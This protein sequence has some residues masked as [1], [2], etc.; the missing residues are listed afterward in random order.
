[1]IRPISKLLVRKNKSQFRLIDNPDS[2]DWNDILMNKAK[3]RIYDD[4]LVFRET[5][6]VFRLKGDILSMITVYDFNNTDS[7]DAKQTINFLDEMKFDIYAKSESFRDMNFIKNFYN[8]RALLVPGL[9]EIIFLLEKPND[10]CKR[11]RLIIHEKQAGNDTNKFD[12]EIVVIFGNLLEYISTTPKQR[13]QILI[14]FKLFNTEKKSE[15]TY[16]LYLS[17]NSH[18]FVC[19]PKYKYSYNRMYT[20]V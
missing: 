10:F 8:K 1:M 6:V 9:H 4:K 15:T 16:Y 7:P 20:Q 14:K 12:N 5:G 18:M 13:T 19:I 17:I 2:D 11:L 3:V